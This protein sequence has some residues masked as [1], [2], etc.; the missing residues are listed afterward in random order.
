MTKNTVDT[1]LN[2]FKDKLAVIILDNNMKIPV[3]MDSVTGRRVSTVSNLSTEVIGGTCFLK[4]KRRDPNTL[5]IYYNLF[6]IDVIQGIVYTEEDFA[7]IDYQMK[8]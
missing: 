4:E 5:E 8:L 2:N 7:P 6:P 3:N 1:I